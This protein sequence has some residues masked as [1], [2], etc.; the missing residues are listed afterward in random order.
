M[1]NNEEKKG[2]GPAL[3]ALILA[4]IGFVITGIVAL[5]FSSLQGM[6][7]ELLAETISAEL[8]SFTISNAEELAF[9]DS[10]KFGMKIVFGGVYFSGGLFMLIAFICD[11]V[12]ICKYYGNKS[13]TK[14]ASTIVLAYIA[15]A[16]LITSVAIAVM[17]CME[18]AAIVDKVMA[19]YYA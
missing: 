5:V 1:S 3:A 10:F 7:E 19:P 9:V 12:A 15:L 13:E 8:G 18:F 2:F 6:I 4:I 16:F 14:A 11:I 17:G